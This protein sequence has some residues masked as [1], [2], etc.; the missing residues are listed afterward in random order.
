MP[1]IWTPSLRTLV[2]FVLVSAYRI[3]APESTKTRRVFAA[4]PVVVTVGESDCK[5]KMVDDS[6]S[7]CG[8]DV[9]RVEIELEVKVE[10][11]FEG[12]INE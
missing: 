2:M 7:V 5:V 10:V 11:E 6:S 8:W 1:V 3:L 12:K 4:P 9:I